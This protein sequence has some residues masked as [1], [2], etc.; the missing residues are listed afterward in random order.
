MSLGSGS[1]TVL[2]GGVEDLF[3]NSIF[4][5]RNLSSSG[6]TCIITSS[7]MVKAGRN[8]FV[9]AMHLA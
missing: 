2:W 6:T 1:Q 5:A 8:T 3:S 4:G 7:T 9:E